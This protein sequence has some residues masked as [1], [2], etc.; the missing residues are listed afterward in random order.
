MEAGLLEE[1]HNAGRHDVA[2]PVWGA[3]GR[4]IFL[5]TQFAFLLARCA[6]GKYEESES[7]ASARSLA[8]P[9]ATSSSAPPLGLLAAQDAHEQHPSNDVVP[10]L[11]HEAAAALLRPY[12]SEKNYWIVLHHGL[13]QGYYWMQHYDQDRN[14]RDALIDSPHYQACVDFCAQLRV[15]A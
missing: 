1:G 12:V 3:R 10:V 8:P 13:F 4:V 14:S 5:K 2:L 11:L 15:Q 9:A 6:P 7:A